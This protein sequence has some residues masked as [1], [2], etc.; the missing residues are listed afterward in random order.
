MQLMQP[1]HSQQCVMLGD[2]HC[3]RACL[4][5]HTLPGKH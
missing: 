4:P 5:Y 3:I 2:V 1:R